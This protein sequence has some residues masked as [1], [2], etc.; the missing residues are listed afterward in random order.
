M[1]AAIEVEKSR[2]AGVVRGHL[3]LFIFV[4]IKLILITL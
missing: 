2:S 4:I 3:F 1:V